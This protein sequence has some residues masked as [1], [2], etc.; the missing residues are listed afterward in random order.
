MGLILVRHT[1]PA[2]AA[3]TCYGR[4]DVGLAETFPKEA[5]AVLAAL[6]AIRRVISSPLTRCLALA[7]YIA[8]AGNLPIEVDERLI[9]L[10]FG[11]WEGQ[12]WSQVREA[13]L[14]A[15]AQDFMH[16]RPH[17]G[18]S[19]AMLRDRV[20]SALTH[21]SAR[22]E[23]IAIVTHAGVIKAAC[24]DEGDGPWDFKPP[25]DFGG[26]ITLP[27]DNQ[28]ADGRLKHD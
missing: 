27:D 9:E 6:P 19:V 28:A 8:A 2:V 3:G 23:P 10:D 15:W 11:A 12:P 1:R 13:D 7:R 14:D 20:T 17:G 25:V 5:E 21:W 26:I 4:L 24:M 16:A 18:E 22:R